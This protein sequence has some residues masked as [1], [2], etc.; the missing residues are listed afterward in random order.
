MKVAA[1]Q[2]K[3]RSGDLAYNLSHA[4]QLAVAA[5]EQ[6]AQIVALP[7]FFTGM[8]APNDT[9][10]DVAMAADRNLAVEMM[11]GLAR[12]FSGS[13]GGSVL[14]A[15]QGELYNRYFFVTPSGAVHA[16]DK[17][18]PTMWENAFYV[19]G[20][21]DGVFDT[22]LGGI[23]AAVCWELIRTQTLR[24]MKGRVDLV[25]TGTHWWHMPENWPVMRDLLKPIGQFN[26]Y[27]SEQAPV[28]FARRIGVPVV[29]ASHCGPL[30][31]KYVLVPG[32]DLGFGYQTR[33]V[34][35]TQIVDHTGFV[36]A[37]RNTSE[38]PG[39]VIADVEI[40]GEADPV[41]PYID[42]KFWLP[43]LPLFHRLYWHQQNWACKSI[44]RRKGR[45]LGLAA[46]EKNR[47]VTPNTP[48][49]DAAE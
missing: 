24:R 6:G 47:A 48:L 20:T 17:D 39:F 36:Q 9:A 34:G 13:I 49:S 11:T 23:G 41:I 37:A 29:Q 44:Y 42:Y 45:A 33:F 5:F 14:L 16:H 40:G 1:V 43:E 10:Y 7:E 38:G 3:T 22:E 25:M 4:E 27:L 28:E 46:A 2:I 8:L 26:R 12:R 35:A 31:G 30:E 15:D 21:D 18:L 32:T 19:G